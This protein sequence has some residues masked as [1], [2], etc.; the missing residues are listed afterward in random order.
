MNIIEKIL[1]AFASIPEA[2]QEVLATITAKIRE[3]KKQNLPIQI[4]TICTHNSRRSHLGQ[5]W[6]QKA[7]QYYGV[8]KV[9]VFSG[10]TEV[11]ACHLNTIAALKRAGFQILLPTQPSD[12]NPVYSLDVGNNVKINL[13]S[14]LYYDESN[15]QKDFIALL[16]CTQA[17][18]GCPFVAGAEARFSL[19]FQDPKVA[20]GTPYEAAAYDEVSMQIAVEM[21][22]MM[23]KV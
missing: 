9:S 14:K 4:I 12:S 3:K 2:R 5:V 13:F 19:P 21:F 23:S 15:P 20:D 22:F 17:D 10:G 6:L 7:A 18:L 1:S 8:E 11:T 16:F